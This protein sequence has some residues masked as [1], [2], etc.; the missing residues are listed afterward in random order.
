MRRNEFNEDIAA[1]YKK[2]VFEKHQRI[3]QQ[4]TQVHQQK[5]SFVNFYRLGNEVRLSRL[6]ERL[7]S[8]LKPSP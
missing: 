2:R 5:N 6:Q 3:N 7:L 8:P 4:V 1:Y